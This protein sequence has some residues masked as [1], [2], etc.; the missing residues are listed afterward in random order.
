[1]PFE[2]DK[3]LLSVDVKFHL[4][5]NQLFSFGDLIHQITSSIK[6]FIRK[7]ILKTTR[8]KFL[9]EFFTF[10]QNYTL[11]SKATF[12]DICENTI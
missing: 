4:N 11:S 9:G 1:M 12:P 6:A 8:V 7:S 10:H 2:P 3:C 5:A